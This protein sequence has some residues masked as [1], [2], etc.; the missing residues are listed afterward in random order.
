MIKHLGAF[1][2]ATSR[3]SNALLNLT[4][5]GT[6]V[7]NDKRD[8][9]GSVVNTL[10]DVTAGGANTF[11]RGGIDYV[12]IDAISA[13]GSHDKL[14]SEL[15]AIGLEAG[16]QF[17]R[18]VSGWLPVDAITAL[19]GVDS[20]QSA[21]AVSV[22][23][24]VG[25]VTTQSV[26]AN[27]ADTVQDLYGL[28]GTGVTVGILS[29]SFDTSPF[30]AID[31]AADVA[32]GDLPDDV[33]VLEDFVGN[34][35][36]EGRAMAQL[37]HDHA[38]GADIQF[39]TAFNGQAGFANNI[40]ALRDAGSDVIVDDII[41]FAEPAFADGIIAQAAAE[42]VADGVSFFSSAG[43]NGAA[44]YQDAFADSGV[45]GFFDVIAPGGSTT[46]DWDPGA[47]IDPVLD[48]LLPSGTTRFVLQWDQPYA[49]TGLASPGSASD[50]DLWLTAAGTDPTAIFFGASS[51]NIGGDPVEVLSIINNGGPI[52]LGLAIELFDGVMPADMRIIAFNFPGDIV[53]AEYAFT[54]PTVYGHSV[55]AGAFGVGASDWDETPA[56]GV[57]PPLIE[58]FSSVGPVEILFDTDGN[59]LAT[60]EMRDAVDFTASQ[61]GNTTFFIGDTPDD[62]DSF[63]NFFGTSASAPNAAA[64]AALMLEANPDLTPAEIEAALEASAIDQDDPYTPGFDVGPDE[65][66]GAGLIQ[67]DLAVREAAFNAVDPALASANDW[68]ANGN[69]G[70]NATFTL[71][72][73]EDLVDGGGVKAWGLDVDYAGG[74]T[75]SSGWTQSFNG[76]V[77]FD[78]ATGIFS[79]VN[80]GFQP[81]LE[82]G[83]TITFAVQVQ[84][85]GFNEDDFSFFFKDLDDAPVTPDATAS[86]GLSLDASD[87]NDW[88]AGLVQQIEITNTG[89]EAVDGWIVKLNLDPGDLA[90]LTLTNTWSA[91][92]Q[93]DGEDI[94]FFAADYNQMVGA[95]DSV[96]FGF[97]ASV[98]GGS[99]FEAGDFDFV[100][101]DDLPLGITAPS[102][103]DFV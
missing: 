15:Q 19:A 21:D 55:A 16:E 6:V 73:T 65:A 37:V 42:V 27:A 70:F 79:T 99:P 78:T 59:R 44:G 96:S 56:F 52:T 54:G 43:N 51:V 2:A 98:S 64:I 87:L 30:F 86:A 66:S 29:D 61:G 100:G 17:G 50:L 103:F 23:S 12:L 48:F 81:D 35:I 53:D 69:G 18:V 82:V 10:T 91:T 67:A 28:D 1:M 20:L 77:E 71:T 94:Y 97:Q 3:L 4:D 45:A 101:L 7:L 26:E 22:G 41:Y 34:T 63:P 40:L 8:A 72:L 38:P 58:D 25:S 84:G 62:P 95:G 11:L 49:S 47:G 36:D 60:P 13:L 32:S 85:A 76:P 24:N 83:D 33:L 39:A 46:H 93:S 89:A 14:L 75:F 9:L 102:G 90:D 5:P 80:S 31:A 74:G 88:G 68:F 57:T 92:Q